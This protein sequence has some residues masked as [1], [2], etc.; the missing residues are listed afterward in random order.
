MR[1]GGVELAGVGIL[2]AADVARVL[3]AGG[4]H[5]EADAEVGDL[6]LAG[7]ADGVEHALDAALAEAAG[8]EDAVEAGE[9]LWVV[10]AAAVFAAGFEALGFDPGDLEL[11]VVGE[12]SV[13]ERF[14]EALVGVFV[15][16]VLADDGDRDF[17][18][19]VVGAVDDVLP[20]GEI[21]VRG[22]RCGGT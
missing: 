1:S 13:D 5:A 7:V 14:L 21:G 20:L 6:V 3:D 2:E 19:R 15:L 12:G 11:E 18:L 22:L 8:D 9:L 17:V 10:I 16:D 4:L